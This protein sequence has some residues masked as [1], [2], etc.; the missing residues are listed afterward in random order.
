MKLP[1]YLK[2]EKSGIHNKGIFA[3]KNITKEK[4]IIQYVG[5]IITKKEAEI[6]AEKVLNQS[7]K[8][9]KNGAVYIF[10]LNKKYDLDGNIKNNPAKYINHSCNPNCE[11]ET[12]NNEI[13]IISIK[14]IKKGQEI[15]YDYGYN[16]DNFKEHPCKCGSKKCIGY[17]V[18]KKYW[19]KLKKKLNS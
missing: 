5:E 10:E 4:K 16:L 19:P 11:T 18:D 15:T 17:I 12:I 9:K 8:N 6:R 14:N 1:K 7:K 13:W 2:C 3:Q